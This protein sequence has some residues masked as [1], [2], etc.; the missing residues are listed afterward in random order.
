MNAASTT[1]SLAQ[2]IV[3]IAPSLHG[4]EPSI[5]LLFYLSAL[6]FHIAGGN[7]FWRFTLVL[8]VTNV[9]ILLVFSF[10]CMSLA[11]FNAANAAYEPKFIDGLSGFMKFMPLAAW[12]FVGVESLSL[13]NDDVH[14]PKETVPHGLVCCVATLALT[15]T[16]VLFM[17]V[18]LPFPGGLLVLAQTSA[19]LNFGFIKMF[20]LS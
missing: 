8:G 20:N 6:W 16:L 10:G 9:A 19:P 4:Y 5:Y 7:W 2:I 11:E 13:A 1:D 17:T 15:G 18:S 14:H 12:F 3:L